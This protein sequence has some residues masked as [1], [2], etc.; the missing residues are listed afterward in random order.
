MTM[1]SVTLNLHGDGHQAGFTLIELMVASLVFVAV[2]GVLLTFLGRDEK[3]RE[4]T[5]Y[6]AESRQSAR[7]ALEFMVSEIR[8]AGSGIS[9]PVV[10]SMDSGDSLILYPVTPDTIGGSTEKITILGQFDGV[11][12][13]VSKKMP[14]ASSVTDVESTDGFVE[15]DLVVITNDSFANLF[16]VTKVLTGSE[17]LQH[18][19]TSPYNQPGGHKPWPPGGYDVGSRVFKVG[20]VTYFVDR[21]DTT[22]PSIM[23]Q[24]GAQTPRIVSEYINA[25][26]LE[27]EL[28]DGTVATMPAD[29]SLIRRVIVTIE[30][31][32]NE[33]SRR[34][35]TRLMSAAKPRCL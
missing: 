25:L 22:C 1:S 26:E 9:V 7:S 19:P 4:I 6:V 35:V 10:T 11:E 34:H 21:Q 28:G 29:P 5:Y 23:R 2:I 20:L 8:M 14:N 16:E 17:K 30:A 3:A 27:Y 31:A 12:T 32:S 33:P 18:N 24:E 15:G 13:R